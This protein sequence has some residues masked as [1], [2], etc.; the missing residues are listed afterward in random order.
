V[1]PEKQAAD[2]VTIRE[3]KLTLVE[4][5]AD[6]LAHEIK[7]PLHSMVIT[8]EV[9]RRRLARLETEPG[10]ELLR[11]TGVI[12]N[13]LERVNQRVDLLLRMV[14]PNRDGDDPTTLAEIFDEL[15]ELVQIECERNRIQLHV[16]LPRE[17]VR[18]RYPRASARQMVLSLILKTLDSVPPGGSLYLTSECTSEG[19]RIHFFGHDP[20]GAPVAPDRSTQNGSYLAVART[21]AERIG[22]SLDVVTPTQT[23]GNGGAG[24]GGRYLL[25][26]PMEGRSADPCGNKPGVPG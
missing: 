15:V 12:N 20:S 14:R 16:E 26:L 10:D 6:D 17:I 18:A 8:L 24:L 5:L 4:R 11:Y 9:L 7:N 1:D 2:L 19:L 3:N 21:L 25:S 23:S 13:E 22:G